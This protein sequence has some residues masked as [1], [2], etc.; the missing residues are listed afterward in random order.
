[1][2]SQPNP[3][4]YGETY[5]IYSRDNNRENIFREERNYRHFLRLYAHHICP[6][7][8]TYAYDARGRLV[9]ARVQRPPFYTEGSIRR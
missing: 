7:A 2:S 6:V 8:T 3:L 9:D 5:H 4:E 1:M